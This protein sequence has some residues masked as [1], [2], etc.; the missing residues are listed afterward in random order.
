M[1]ELRRYDIVC[2]HRQVV[3]GVDSRAGGY[4]LLLQTRAGGAGGSVSP[5]FLHGP[6]MT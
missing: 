5:S 6:E 2:R 3:L 1:S 4:F